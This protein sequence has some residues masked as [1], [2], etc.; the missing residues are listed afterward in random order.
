VRTGNSSHAQLGPEC[1]SAKRAYHLNTGG[2]L[3]FHVFQFAPRDKI[4][5]NKKELPDKRCGEYSYWN[6]LLSLDS[7]A[8][9][10]SHRLATQLR[11]VHSANHYCPSGCFSTLEQRSEKGKFHL[12]SIVR[13]SE[14][15]SDLSTLFYVNITFSGYGAFA[16]Y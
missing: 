5:G 3:G 4:F 13:W 12:G 1:R 16:L 6:S 14:K 11:L 10:R 15:L 2:C 9:S 7:H 8:H